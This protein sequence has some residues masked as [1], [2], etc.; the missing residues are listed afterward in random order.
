MIGNKW[1]QLLKDEYQKE[2]FTNLME[3]IKKAS[4]IFMQNSK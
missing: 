2:Y 3:F 4:A 1:D